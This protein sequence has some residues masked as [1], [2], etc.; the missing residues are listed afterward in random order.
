M[1]YKSTQQPVLFCVRIFFYIQFS[2]TL[3]S[4]GCLKHWYT[5]FGLILPFLVTLFSE[6][7]ILPAIDTSFEYVNIL[8]LPHS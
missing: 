4:Q 2:E 5:L 1:M 6:V 8:S 3:C 7:L